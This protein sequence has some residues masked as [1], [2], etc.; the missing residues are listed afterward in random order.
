MTSSDFYKSPRHLKGFSRDS[1]SLVQEVHQSLVFMNKIFMALLI[2]GLMGPLSLAESPSPL[3]P[4][5]AELNFQSTELHIAPDQAKLFFHDF[6]EKNNFSVTA[7]GLVASLG[8][9]LHKVPQIVL[10]SLN[11]FFGDSMIFHFSIIDYF[12]K[13]Y[14]EIP[15]KV[16]SPSAG[17]LSRPD[18]LDFTWE[19]FPVRFP[20]FKK[21][22]DRVEQIELMRERLPGFFNANVT[23]GAFIFMDLTTVDK[24][25]GELLKL[26]PDAPKTVAS[27]LKRVTEKNQATSVG[28]TNLHK[29]R[30]MTG[31]AGIEVW[32]NGTEKVFREPVPSTVPTIYESWL[33]N[34]SALF[35]SN[36]YLKWDSRYFVNEA[37]DRPLVREILSAQGLD[38][39]KKYAFLNLNTFGGDKVRDLIPVYSQI[40]R[41]MV[42]ETLQTFPDWNLVVTFPEY[43]FGPEVQAEAIKLAQETKGRL[44]LI[45]SSERELMPSIL[46]GA[47]WMISYDS[48][49][50]HLG[51]FL[52]PEKVL[53]IGLWSSGAELWRRENQPFFKISNEEPVQTL[54]DS[55]S[56]WIRTVGR[57]QL[58]W[59][60]NR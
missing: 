49:L 54:I 8:I 3:D 37:E 30:I 32:Q 40:L 50:V 42:S 4:C 57:H 29:N 56:E 23:P 34:F 21:A 5:L 47:E 41:A 1:Y 13:N 7:D 43:Q 9:D 16:I 2:A 44:A 19:T 53:S 6:A 38:P 39:E 51:S 12:R 15:L 46:A 59:Q 14:P 10:F 18:P 27:E 25:D 22:T 48:G 45:P 35:G 55:V 24:A 60:N 58:E 36:A 20:Q 33:Q 11:G 28:L 26:K 17:I 31:I 52:P